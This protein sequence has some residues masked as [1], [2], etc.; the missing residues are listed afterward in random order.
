MTKEALKK[1]LKMT[2]HEEIF[3]THYVEYIDNRLRRFFSK[4][5]VIFAIFGMCVAATA[6]YTSKVSAES[7]SGVCAIKGESVK[8]AALGDQFLKDNP[9]GIPGVSIDSLKRSTNNAKQTVKALENVECSE[10]DLAI[11]LPTQSTP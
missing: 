11:E 6:Y 4:I 5:V 3:F 10:T 2:E 1:E 9:D 7:H 8:R